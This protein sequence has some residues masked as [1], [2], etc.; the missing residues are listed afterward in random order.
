M[1]AWS[2][3]LLSMFSIFKNVSSFAPIAVTS[4][5]SGQ[6]QLPDGKYLS[7][8]RE[9]YQANELVYAGIEEL[10]TSAA[11]PHLVATVG[12]RKET[13]GWRHWD[14][15]RWI[16]DGG[17]E[18]IALLNT[19]NPFMD[20]FSFFANVIMHL[21]IDGNAFACIVRSASGKPVELWLMRPDRVRIVPDKVNYIARYEYDSG[22]GAPYPI[23]VQDVI[24]WKKRSPTNDWRGQSPLM[25]GAG[26]IDMDNYMR[27]FATT[28]FERHGMPSG[29]LNIEGS[30]TP[31]E[32]K[33][34]QANFQREYAGPQGWHKLLIIGKNKATFTPMT[35][36]LGNSGLVVPELDEIAEARILMLLGVPPE[37]I[38]ARVG[39]R[40]SSYANK[41]SAR[42]SFWDE[43]L[44]PL[45]EEMD[46]PLNLRL[47]PNYPKVRRIAFDLS[48]VRAL[49]EDEDKVHARI[50]AD[51][52]GGLVS[53]E[54]GRA[55]LGYGEVPT[56]GTFF[57]P[58]TVVPVPAAKVADD[59]VDLSQIRVGTEAVA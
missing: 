3:P 32:R 29:M 19:P 43:T 28:F 18:L 7:F 2:E 13:E 4:F 27:K 47:V 5:Q 54:E 20:R 59:S 26:R 51:L 50:R 23:P 42:E 16:L 24:H 10:A 37:L 48:G 57:I 1:S 6:A 41:R 52:A 58:S 25:A 17:H 49:Q 30:T 31:E 21:Y 53:L 9:G 36:N 33:E 44:S 55:K 15:Q 56:E 35:Q 11:E 14:G 12:D 8:A 46:G 40:N 38:A 39:M 45:Y 22:E 34:I